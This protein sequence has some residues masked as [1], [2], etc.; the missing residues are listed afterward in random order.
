MDNFKQLH[1]AFTPKLLFYLRDQQGVDSEGLTDC[2][3]RIDP[4]N[5]LNWPI[6][7][8][9][10]AER[11]GNDWL[12]RQSSPKQMRSD[13]ERNRRDC[14]AKLGPE[15]HSYCCFKVA[16]GRTLHFIESIPGA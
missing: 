8:D 1:F 9:F 13:V 14:N 6:L 12:A 3:I 11:P 7:A 5:Q 15:A 4:H 16:K 2:S 10:G